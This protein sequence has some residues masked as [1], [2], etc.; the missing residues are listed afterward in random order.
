MRMSVV[1]ETFH[2]SAVVIDIQ[3]IRQFLFIL[4]RDV[5]LAAL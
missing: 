4:E 5:M 3:D 2:H 1:E